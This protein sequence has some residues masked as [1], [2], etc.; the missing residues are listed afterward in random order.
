MIGI[1][2]NMLDKIKTYSPTTPS[3]RGTIRLSREGVW[4]GKP[5]KALTVGLKKT[6]GRNNYGR[7]TTRHIGGGHKQRYRIIDFKRNSNL[8][9]KAQVERIEYDPNRNCLIALIKY[10][11]T[12]EFAYIL[13][14][15]NLQVGSEI[16]S[17]SKEVD[18]R[19][20]NCAKLHYIPVATK[21]HNIE[22]K[23][24]AGGKIVRSG[25]AFAEIMDKSNGYAMVKLPSGEKRLISLE[26]RA[27]IGEVSGE[28]SNLIKIGKAGRSRHLGIRPTVRGVVMN[29]VDHP[30]GGGEGKT[31][32]GRH[33]VTPWGKNTKGQKTRHNKRTSK[34]ILV[35]CR[36][37]RKK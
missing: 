33:P 11:S 32:G 10:I 37:A 27:T 24:G 16:Y 19:I 17:A 26:C 5:F 12:G 4:K 18:V 23:I 13:A 25:G 31:S 30:H 34:F 20:G 22:L 21:I 2:K 6:G 35:N 36:S 28:K 8:D 3:L 1:N 9:S 7:I 29:P 14:P 15:K